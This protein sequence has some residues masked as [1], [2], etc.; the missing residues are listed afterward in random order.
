MCVVNNKTLRT[1][2][3]GMV[4]GEMNDPMQYTLFDL[5]ILLKD[6]GKGCVN[7][8]SMKDGRT[9]KKN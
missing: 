5:K 8:P 4:L 3:L 6:E 2:A 7:A 9:K 1:T